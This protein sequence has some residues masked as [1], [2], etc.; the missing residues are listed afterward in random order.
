MKYSILS[1][2]VASILLVGCGGDSSDKSIKSTPDSINPEKP[3]QKIKKISGQ[4]EGYQD[5]KSKFAEILSADGEIYKA[6]INSKGQYSIFD[7][8]KYP[9]L[10][11]IEKNDNTYLYGGRIQT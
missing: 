10:I 1:V 7:E 8:I 5:L 11:R 6:E 3:V 2:L 9:Y 4:V